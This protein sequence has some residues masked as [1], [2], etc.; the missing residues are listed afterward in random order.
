MRM[1]LEA[2]FSQVYESRYA[3]SHCPE[4]RDKTLFDTTCPELSVYVE[5]R[6]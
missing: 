6:K 5:C 1:L 2:G 4:L 3:Q